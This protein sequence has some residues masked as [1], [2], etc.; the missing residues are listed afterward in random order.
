MT[1]VFAATIASLNGAINLL[2]LKKFDLVIID[3]ASQIPEPHLLAVLSAKTDDDKP[4]VGKIVMIATT[5]N[6]RPL[7][8][9]RRRKPRFTS[10]NF[11][12]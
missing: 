11:S 3:E 7:C 9:S 2:K 4:A 5:N 10:P 12:A 1:R 6:S 8:S